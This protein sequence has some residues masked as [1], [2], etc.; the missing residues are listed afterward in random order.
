M[1]GCELCYTSDSQSFY[2]SYGNSRSSQERGLHYSPL[3]CSLPGTLR[4]VSFFKFSFVA[5]L[6]ANH[7]ALRLR[8]RISKSINFHGTLPLYSVQRELP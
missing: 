6:L 3:P 4:M 7:T 8:L 2:A 5:F 1:K